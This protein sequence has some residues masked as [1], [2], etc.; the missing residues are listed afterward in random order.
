LVENIQREDLNAIDVALSYGFETHAGFFKA[1]KREFSCS[2][3]KYNDT[4]NC[5]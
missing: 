1:F 2:P 5:C 3:T 4:N